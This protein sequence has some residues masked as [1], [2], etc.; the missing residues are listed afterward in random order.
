MKKERAALLPSATPE[1]GEGGKGGITASRPDDAAAGMGAG[2]AEIQV[3][4]RRAVA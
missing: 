3:C 2:A 4:Y 1:I